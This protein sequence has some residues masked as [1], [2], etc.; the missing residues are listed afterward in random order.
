MSTGSGIQPISAMY[1]SST[2][3][4]TVIISVSTH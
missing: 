2:V 1:T 3:K 4:G